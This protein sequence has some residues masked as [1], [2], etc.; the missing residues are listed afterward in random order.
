MTARRGFTIPELVVAMLILTVGLL[1]LASTSAF[2]ARQINGGN[3]MAVGASVAQARFDS[4]TSLSCQSLVGENFA[5]A[6]GT[7]TTRGIYESWAILDSN[8]TKTIIDTI[9]VPGRAERLAYTT[10]IPCRDI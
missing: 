10:K 4:L 7:S 2:V 6:R 5:V 3:R 9:T 1:G 8:D